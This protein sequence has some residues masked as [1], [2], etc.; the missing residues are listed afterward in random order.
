MGNA[1]IFVN[2]VDFIAKVIKLA[3]LSPDDVKIVCSQNPLNQKKLGEEYTVCKPLGTVKKINFYT[4]TCFEGSDVFDTEGKTYIVSDK[5]R[6]HTLLDI[7]TLVIQICGRIRDSRYKDTVTHIFSGQRYDSVNMDE[8]RA[9]C[10]DKYSQSIVLATKLNNFSEAERSKLN[11]IAN[12]LGKEYM[13][14]GENNTFEADE[15]LLNLDIINFKIHQLVYQNKITVA[16]EYQKQGFEVRQSNYTYYA[17]RLKT[18]SDSKISFKDLF[19]EYVDLLSSPFGHYSPELKLIE[20]ER[21]LIKEAYNKLG[22][23]RVAQ[24]Y[25]NQTNVKKEI[26]KKTD[27]SNL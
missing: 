21:P 13:R 5:K 27:E 2:S 7:S 26:I 9:A 3:R 4:S 14:I 8:F 22:I 23:D 16:G 25:F 20:K 17:D 1:H 6:Q 11:R 24:L 15:N 12:N 19:L 10:L 18:D